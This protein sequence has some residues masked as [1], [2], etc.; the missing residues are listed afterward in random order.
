MFK[1]LRNFFIA[2]G[3]AGYFTLGGVAMAKNAESWLAPVCYHDLPEYG[4]YRWNCLLPP[5]P[6]PDDYPASVAAAEIAATLPE[7]ANVPEVGNPPMPTAPELAEVWEEFAMQENDAQTNVAPIEQPAYFSATDIR[8]RDWW[9][10][11]FIVNDSPLVTPPVV[12][13]SC[14]TQ[15][16]GCEEEAIDSYAMLEA[17]MFADESDEVLESDAADY[18]I[19]EVV[20]KPVSIPADCVAELMAAEW[21]MVQ[22]TLD[23][24]AKFDLAVVSEYAAD[25]IASS[26][27]WIVAKPIEIVVEEP[28]SEDAI[29]DELFAS[30]DSSMDE[31]QQSAGFTAYTCMIPYSLTASAEES[32]ANYAQES[33]VTET[34]VDDR[35]ETAATMQKLAR[36]LDWVGLNILRV[37]DHLDSWANQALLRHRAGQ[38][39]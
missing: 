33:E 12:D 30:S 9:T 7:F 15:W 27:P 5:P 28:K 17:A 31:E 2:L 22:E 29:A 11:T 32:P 39:R 13:E 37:A 8:R 35:V 3:F 36:Q 14:H 20:A 10:P 19:E 6:V 26:A 1:S 25:A 4:N 23:L 21:M 24:A 38:V 18:P 34:L 16:Y